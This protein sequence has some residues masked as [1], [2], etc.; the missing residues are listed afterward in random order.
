ML[1]SNAAPS[2]VALAVLTQDQ[3]FIVVMVI[4]V[5]VDSCAKISAAGQGRHII[6]LNTN[7]LHNDNRYTANAPEPVP[8]TVVEDPSVG[9]R[10]LDHSR[11]FLHR[12]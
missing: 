1:T 7:N 6:F 9:F 11:R 2:G 12:N 5:L 3:Y 10:N 4:V 8:I